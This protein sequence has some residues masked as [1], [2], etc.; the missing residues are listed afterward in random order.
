MVNRTARS[1]VLDK[2]QGNFVMG[3][4][5]IPEPAPGTV[6]MKIEL[7]G[8][9]GTDVHTWQSLVEDLEYPIALGH[10]IV[11]VVEALGEGVETDYIGK[12]LQV[13][14]RIGIIPAIHCHK[15]YFCTIVKT[16]EK[17]IDWKTYGTWPRADRKPHFTGGYGDY[18]YIHDQNSVF[19]KMDASPQRGVFLEP[20]A[21]VV[22]SM[23]H[24]R[25]EPGDTVVVNGAGP[26][27]LLTIGL[28]KTAGASKVIALG[29]RNRL[30]LELAKRMGADFTLCHVDIP[31]QEKRK[32]KVWEESLN[33]Y[34]ADVVFNTVGSATGFGESIDYVRDSGTLVEVGNFVDSGT[35][36]FNPCKHL[37]EK[38][39]R[40]IGS[41]DNEA[42][43]YVRAL[44]IISDERLPIPDL[45]THTVPLH[46]L[47]ECLSA[48]KD[49]K[50][51]D[52]K[53][54]VKIV[55]DPGV[56]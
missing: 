6:L 52:G 10:E 43:H 24:A 49:G 42:E 36:P 14:D 47:Q 23:L 35:I 48:I 9:C 38:G 12:P 40:I 32:E 41:F 44:P 7:C 26:I 54:F 11:G 1:Y 15:C 19:V 55:I 34:G 13:G 50:K 37:L 31:A 18:L 56:S 5:E 39:I 29:R 46:R 20:M 8:V 2:P 4:Y 45:I 27:G 3:D 16:P 51:L 21:I 28:A 33:G 53:E 30:R 22:H 25:I 17:C